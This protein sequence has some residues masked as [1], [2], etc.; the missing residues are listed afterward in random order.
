MADEIKITIEQ[1]VQDVKIVV[2]EFTIPGL[3]SSDA[4][5]ALV[6]GADKK[7][8]V[9]NSGGGGGGTTNL[10]KT[11]T[12]TTNVIGNDNGTGFT[13][14][15]GNGTDAG[16]SENNFTDAEKSKL[17]SITEAFTTAL[18][19]A[20]DG[21][22]TWIATNGANVIS[23][24]TWVT[25]NGANVLNHLSN[26]SNPHNTTAAQVGLGNVDNTSD[27]NKP[28]STAQQTALNLK[29][30]LVGGFVPQSQLP[31]YVDDILEFANLAS[32]PITGEIGKIYIAI[33]SSKQ[34]RWTGSA[35]LQITNGLIATT[36]DVPEGVSN[37]YFTAA[38][39]LATVLTGI[40]FATG[41]EIVSTDTVLQAFGKIQKQISDILTALSGKEPTITAGTIL[42]YWR[43]DKT[44]QP[45]P[46][47]TSKRTHFIN[48][49]S[50][51]TVSNFA[52]WYSKTRDL[53]TQGGTTYSPYTNLNPANDFADDIYLGFLN[54]VPF[55]CK[56]KSVKLSMFCN[57]AGSIPFDFAI[58]KVFL[59]ATF[60]AG[61]NTSGTGH[62][63]IARQ[64]ETQINSGSQKNVEFSSG[65]LDTATTVAKNSIVKFYF[66]NLFG[67]SAGSCEF[68]CLVELEEI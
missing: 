16:L 18:K 52:S 41:G 33:D 55:D 68:S 4:N 42:Q 25:T 9:S 5:N 14:N 53:E 58:A 61:V 32:F 59:P 7:L 28:I 6:L 19:T 65:S 26:T 12:K 54:I 2:A 49:S 29:A 44:W 47:V 64:T 30:D 1:V 39:V 43:G 34:Y 8:F 56:I 57:N 23:A 60:N 63:I 3:I 15:V 45:F 51:T 38:R 46:T 20:Y 66:K 10:S 36:N 62:K 31:S 40:S 17:A 50:R 37:L 35:Y 22:V 24:Y 11:T 67:A 21:A 27:I 48:F 13:L